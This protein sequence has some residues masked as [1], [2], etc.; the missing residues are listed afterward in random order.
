[1]RYQISGS[2]LLFRVLCINWYKRL[3]SKNVKVQVGVVGC[4]RNFHKGTE[5]KEINL[6]SC[7]CGSELILI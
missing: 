6:R 5:Y 4:D 7:F 3:A 2:K 1:M